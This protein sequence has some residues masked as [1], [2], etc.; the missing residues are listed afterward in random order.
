MGASSFFNLTKSSRPWG[1]P[2]GFAG[3]GQPLKP[4][5]AR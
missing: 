3:F 4:P 1:A 2:T 5:L